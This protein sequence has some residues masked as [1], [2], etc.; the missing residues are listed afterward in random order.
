M[1]E[2]TTNLTACVVTVTIPAATP[3]NPS[4]WKYEGP[5]VS[6]G[7][8]R[9]PVNAQWI[10]FVLDPTTAQTFAFLAPEG[11]QGIS[12]FIVQSWS[13]KSVVVEDTQTSSGKAGTFTLWVETISK[14]GH[15]YDGGPQVINTGDPF[16]S[17]GR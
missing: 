5:C 8:L 12:D 2:I 4:T 16:G 6:G 17:G 15:F 11:V 3:K 1:S 9:V 14:P 13:A 7:G 10:L